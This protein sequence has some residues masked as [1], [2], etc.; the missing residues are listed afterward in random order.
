MKLRESL[1]LFRRSKK[2]PFLELCC[3]LTAI[4]RP[5]DPIY[6][7][8]FLEAI[9]GTLLMVLTPC[10]LSSR[11]SE[12]IIFIVTQCPK[13]D[14]IFESFGTSKYE[15]KRSNPSREPLRAHAGRSLVLWCLRAGSRKGGDGVGPAGG[16]RRLLAEAPN[17]YANSF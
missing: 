13:K 1:G 6:E 7:G 5:N 9:L 8:H 15:A 16:A 17:Q 10:H 14:T 12:S 2:V 4:G 11:C 3:M